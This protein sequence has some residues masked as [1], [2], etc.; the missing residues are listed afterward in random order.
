[1]IPFIY[2][3]IF[4][5]RQYEEDDDLIGVGLFPENQRKWGFIG[6][7]GKLIIPPV[8]DEVRWFDK[9][10][11]PVQKDGKW[12]IIDKNGKEIVPFIYDDMSFFYDELSRVRNKYGEY[13]FIDIDGKV[14]IPLIYE[15]IYF[16][17]RDGFTR[18]RKYGKYGF[19]NKKGVS[20]YPPP[21]F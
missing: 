16:L 13:G 21:K 4:Y 9:N 10:R 2:D 17:W 3:D 20:P 1:V 7:N 5:S 15:G 8:Y 6:G 18:V 12:G 14:V 11:C 19:I